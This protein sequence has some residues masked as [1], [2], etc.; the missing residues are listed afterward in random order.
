MMYGFAAV[1]RDPSPFPMMKIAAQ[2]PPNDL[3]RMQGHAT[4]APMAYKERPHI[5]TILYP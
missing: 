4:K 2:K 3:Y 5:N 1:S